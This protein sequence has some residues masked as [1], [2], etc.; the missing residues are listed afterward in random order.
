MSDKKKTA[1]KYIAAIGLGVIVFAASTCQYLRSLY[2]TL[3]D[4]LFTYMS[5]ISAANSYLIGNQINDALKYLGVL[6]RTF[7]QMEQQAVERLMK[8]IVEDT[9]FEGMGILWQDGAGISQGCDP[10]PLQKLPTFQKAMDEKQ[11]TAAPYMDSERQ[12]HFCYLIPFQKEQ[13]SGVLYAAIPG[14]LLLRHTADFDISKTGFFCIF[15]SNGNVAGKLPN[16]ITAEQCLPQSLLIT[17][18]VHFATIAGQDYCILVQS[19]NQGDWSILTA[20]HKD[21]LYQRYRNLLL[22]AAS[23]LCIILLVFLA[24][25]GYIF[26]IRRKTRKQLN[27]LAYCDTLTGGAN[28]NAMRRF[29]EQKQQKENHLSG[30]FVSIDVQDFKGIN[31]LYGYNAGDKLLMTMYQC[32]KADIKEGEFCARN[33]VDRFLLLWNPCTQ[34]EIQDR[35]DTMCNRITELFHRDYPGAQVVLCMGIY[36]VDGKEDDYTVCVN[37]ADYALKQAKSSKDTPIQLYSD[38]SHRQ[39]MWEKSVESKMEQALA[40]EE[41]KLYLQPKV[42]LQD[43]HTRAAEAL[44]RWD[45]QEW[46][47]LTPDRF[48]PLFEQNGFLEQLDLYMFRKV[49]QWIAKR[50]V[51][52]MIPVCVSVNLSRAYLFRP[53]LSGRLLDIATQEGGNP[54][55]IELEITES[56]GNGMH[57]ELEKVIGQLHEAGF[58]VSL[59][60][61]GSGYSSLSLLTSLSIDTMKLDRSFLQNFHEQRGKLVIEEIIHLAHTLNITTVM[62]GVETEEQVSFLQKAGC[63][64]IQGYYFAKPLL[65]DDFE[66]FIR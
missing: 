48:I 45:S 12:M 26:W 9:E 22:S 65:P 61:F 53:G 35:A 8:Q 11:A 41:F 4:D 3:R 66:C 56:T 63:D 18:D 31:E 21:F 2:V 50:N 39:M 47:F 59:D 20:V 62:E 33:S 6:S 51:E 29:L 28:Q 32:M 64:M 54:S 27:R 7:N 46:G 13:E 14:D 25:N 24:V 57:D 15:D 42:T 36:L 38:A 44:V 10:S 30:A 52:E 55:M 58:S 19:F 43:G 34:K 17:D 40:D 1:I 5:E 49:C 37:R 60:D 16:Q 23:N